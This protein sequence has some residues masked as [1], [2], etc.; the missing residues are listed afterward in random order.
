MIIDEDK[1]FVLSNYRKV[2]GKTIKKDSDHHTTI[3]EMK[4]EYTVKKPERVEMFNYKNI[5]CQ[6]K[7]YQITN[8]TTE[9]T[10]CFQKDGNVNDQAEKWFGKLQGVFHSSFKKIRHSCKS[11]KT[12][13]SSRLEERRSELV[14]LKKAAEED[15]D[16]IRERISNLEDEISD[17]VAEE[18]RNKI[19]DNFKGL[20]NSEG[21]FQP[22]G[23]WNIKRKV[24]PKNKE[25]LP[26]AKK[27]CDGRIVTARS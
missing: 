1:K 3:M 5:E 27:D 10:K 18:N 7:F 8:D 14:K 24:F 26:F 9:L 23:M 19:V 13:F 2:K 22:N 12:E 17:S 15:K 20:S 4:I 16:E 11:R 6:E 25:F 21:T